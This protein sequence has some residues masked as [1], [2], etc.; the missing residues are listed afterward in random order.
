M[1]NTENTPTEKRNVDAHVTSQ[2]KNA[3]E[4]GVSNRRMPWHTSG[5]FAFCPI[6]VTS[7]K[8]RSA[9]PWNRRCRRS[10]WV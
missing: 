10:A 5:K 8:R 3:I 2:I 1:S 6:N 9:L 7:K 4:Q